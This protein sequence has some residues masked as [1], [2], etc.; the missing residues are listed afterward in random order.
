MLTKEQKARVR[1]EYARIWDSEKM[2]DFC[3]AKVAVL[4]ELP[5]GD[6][7]PI[8]KESI[9]KDFCF[10]ESGYDA[11]EASHMAHV[12]RTSESYFKRE[13]MK[14]HDGMIRDIDEQYYTIHA[15]DP[16]LPNFVLLISDRPYISSPEDGRLRH[17]HFERAGNV[18]D[19]LG[20]SC[21]VQ[22]LPGST[23]EIHGNMYRVPTLAE[24]CSIKMAWELARKEHEKKVDAY[25]KRYG[26]SKVNSWTYWRDA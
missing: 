6:F 2:I 25:L 3:T 24:L 5:G 26:T 18:I 22:E 11:D 4:A 21:R 14:K 9:E 23:V 8:E 12:A 19:A 10:G 7:I 16:R 17:T 20:G 15:D 13:N 1:A